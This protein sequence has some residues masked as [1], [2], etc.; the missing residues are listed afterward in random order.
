MRIRV[1]SSAVNFRTSPY[2]QDGNRVAFDQRFS[3]CGRKCGE[4][5]SEGAEVGRRSVIVAGEEGEDPAT[6]DVLL[7]EGR[8]MAGR[9]VGA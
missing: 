5:R 4:P 3:E 8:E 7:H 9:E 1:F 2:F 6:G